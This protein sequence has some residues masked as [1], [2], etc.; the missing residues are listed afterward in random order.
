M[1]SLRISDQLPPQSAVPPTAWQARCAEPFTTRSYRCFV[2]A[3]R[4]VRNFIQ[5]ILQH[6]DPMLGDRIPGMFFFAPDFS[7]EEAFCRAGVR[8]RRA[9]GHLRT[10]LSANGGSA[11]LWAHAAAE[12]DQAFGID[13]TIEVG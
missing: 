2:A 8:S 1:Q 12:E 3:D 9:G 13:R 6:L 7:N 4:V 5:P 11:A 10:R